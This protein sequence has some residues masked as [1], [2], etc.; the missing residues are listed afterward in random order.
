ME[1]SR[2]NTEIRHQQHEFH[3]SDFI[4]CFIKEINLYDQHQKVFF[5]KWLKI[6]LDEHTSADLSAL[7]HKYDVKWSTVLQL[8]EKHKFQYLKTELE[9]ISED[10]Q[11]AAL[12]LEHIM[13]EIGQI[14]ESCL[15]VKK[16]KKDLQVHFSSLPSLAAEMMISGSPLELMDGDAAHVPVIW[17]SAVLD[18]LVQ[19]LGDQRVFVLSVLGIQSSGKSTILNAMFGLQFAVSAG[20]C[21]RGAFMQLVRVSEEMKTQMNFDYILVVDTEG[22]H[23]PELAGRST[24]RHDNELATFVV[25]IGNLTLINILGEN[26]AE[27]QDILQIVVHAFMRMKKV[28]LNPSCVFVHQNISDVTAGEKNMEGRRRLQEKLDEMTKLAAEEEVCDAERFSDVIKFDVQND[29]KYFAHLWEGNPPM[30]PP[31][32]VYCE[33]I[34]ELKKT[35]ISHASKSH[36]MSLTHLKDHIKHLWEALLKEQFVFSFGNSLETAAY[37]KLQNEY[38]KWSL[39]LQKARKV[40]ENKLQNEI[41]NEAIHEV[42]ETYLQRELSKTSKKVE[43]SMSEFFEKDAYA[44][45]LIQWKPLSETKIKELQENIVRETKGKLNEILQHRDLKKKTEERKQLENTLVE[46]SKELALKL[47]DKANDE[48]TLKKEF[49]LIWENSVKKIITDTDI[50]NDVTQV[51]SCCKQGNKYNN[52]LDSNY[53]EY[54]S[55]RKSSEGRTKQDVKESTLTPEDEAKIRSIVKYVIQQTDTLIQSFKISE[56]GYNI[57]CIQQLTDYIKNSVKEHQKKCEKFELQEEFFVDLVYF[58][59]NRAKVFFIDQHRLFKE[60]N[61]PD[62]YTK[63]KREE[64]YSIFQKHCNGATLTAIFGEI[65][66]QKLKEPIEQSVY[67]NTAR[68]LTEEIRSNCESLNGSRSNLE[69]HILKTL[70]EEEDF[71]KYMS[72]IHNPRDHFNSFI[73]DEVSQY[74]TDQ[75]SVS[76]LPKMEENIKLL[77]QKIMRAAHESTEH[78]QV[79]SRD[80]GLWLKSFTQQ[81]SDEPIFS[82]KDLSEVKHDDVDFKLLEDVIKQKLSA[83]MSEISS[84]FNTNTFPVKLDYKFRP[85]ELLIDPLCQCCWVQCPF[86]G[87][88][89]T[90]DTENHDGDHSVPLHRV[91]GI[92]G[93]HYKNTRNLCAND[94]T[95]LVASDL[96]VHTPNGWFSLR[97]YRRAGG[98]Y[99]D[100]SI[101]PDLS[102]QPYW[103]WFVCRFQEDLEKYH[104]KTFDGQGRIPYEWRTHSKQYAIDSLHKL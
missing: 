79:N 92:D 73:R 103:K 35:I 44:E 27:M 10:L 80:V 43:K 33:N 66:C 76:V 98:V 88:T 47:K 22:L 32:P 83:L 63:K 61:D 96:K 84:R 5:L 28:R 97:D 3:I 82:E 26:L 11:A 23:A 9:T 31:N 24:R 54:V 101:T 29:V 8:K 90:N 49:D 75:F 36:R 70:A 50:L 7:H 95:D 87:A 18:Q 30:A 20:R 59:C 45:I 86:C 40:I 60:A 77:Q 99:A 62:L 56:K 37:K 72:Y 41:K 58:I 13:R 81:L 6:L 55:F 91:T 48:E 1:I 25:G 46:K 104:N 4:K 14:Y 42:E 93:Q 89:C 67:K 78:V 65:I 102:K 39:S 71:D 16:N 38:S 53:S 100:W 94:C 12:G 21:T 74:I 68:D 57:S 19:K 64:Y 17:I 69:K 2:K 34:Q 51:L 15:S 85:D 52:I